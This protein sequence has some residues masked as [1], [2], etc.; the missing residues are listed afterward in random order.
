MGYKHYN[1][2]YK[3]N[4]LQHLQ[5]SSN[6]HQLSDRLNKQEY[7][8]SVQN[9]YHNLWSNLS[10]FN[11]PQEHSFQILDYNHKFLQHSQLDN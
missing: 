11:K 9:K 7:W 1:L 8:M 3:A 6:I 5:D 2:R 10:I 4:I